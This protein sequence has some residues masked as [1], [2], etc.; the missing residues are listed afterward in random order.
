MVGSKRLVMTAT[1][2][3]RVTNLEVSQEPDQCALR[4]E[5]T[6]WSS[7]IH[8]D[9]Q[10]AY[11]VHRTDREQRRL[12]GKAVKC[13]RASN[14]KYSTSPYSKRSP[15]WVAASQCVL[16]WPEHPEA[17]RLGSDASLGFKLSL[18]R[19]L[20]QNSLYSCFYTNSKMR[21]NIKHTIKTQRYHRAWDTALRSL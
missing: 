16:T 19:S 6:C 7:H 21:E 15:E 13:S 1:Q 5:R 11:H 18:F 10:I 14:T 2:S 8:K 4:V 20:S 17:E 12:L 3:Q 9:L